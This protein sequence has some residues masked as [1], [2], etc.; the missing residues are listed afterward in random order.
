M[1]K[2]YIFQS[3]S[4]FEGPTRPRPAAGRLAQFLLI[5]A[6]LGILLGATSAY[7]QELPV[8]AEP[9]VVIWRSIRNDFHDP[10]ISPDFV[11]QVVEMTPPTRLQVDQDETISGLLKK[12]FNISS[13]WT[14]EIYQQML[15]RIAELNSL[16]DVNKVAAGSALLVPQIPMVGKKYFKPPKAWVGQNVKT[17]MS[18][19]ENA[20]VGGKVTKV[21][22][23]GAAPQREVQYFSVPLS[24]AGKY[25]LPAYAVQGASGPIKVDL[26]QDGIGAAANGLLSTSVATLIRSKLS[27]AVDG[28]K[29]VLV[30]LD[31]SVPDSME[32]AASKRFVIA[33]SKTIRDAYSLGESPY[34][35]D[36]EDQP[37]SLAAEDPDSLFP[38]LRTHASLIKQS[39]SEFTALDSGK[40]VTVIYMPLG[41]TQIGVAPL[42]KEIV[43]LGQILKIVRPS[44]PPV[45]TASRS[46]REQAKAVTEAIIDSNP[47]AF[48]SGVLMPI[49]GNELSV[50]TDSLLLEAMGIVMSYYADV[51]GQPYL[52]SFSWTTPKFTFPTYFEAGTYGIKFAAAGNQK[53]VHSSADFLQLELEYASRA[54]TSKD[55]VVVMNSTGAA[56]G[57]PSNVF[58][59]DGLS[60]AT[61]AYPGSVTEK[62]CGTSFST[63]RVA[64]LTAAKEAV[65]GKRL[66]TPVGKQAKLSWL[67]KHHAAILEF[68]QSAQTDLL[69]RYNLDVQKFFSK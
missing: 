32:Y 27:A 51:T 8:A 26:L 67:G 65:F 58:N 30:I 57:C 41:A 44:L 69:G 53:K 43:Y 13:T 50:T 7:P 61:V 38:N 46:Q 2:A 14:P 6:A 15:S 28:P 56:V 5:S 23:A 16:A 63:P 31:D 42:L 1:L 49:D 10:T 35:S 19:V 12:S 21:A 34:L 64:W 40:R 36:V 55:F 11:A 47:V 39:L 17:S 68:R 29:P 54:A 20:I 9:H 45:I 4:D 62:F 52:L 37:D 18:W 48:K 59:D 33:L 60:V 22:P 66:A 25:A 3:V 24:E